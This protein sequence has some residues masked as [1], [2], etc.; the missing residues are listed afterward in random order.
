MLVH[1]NQVNGDTVII[2]E[3]LE[4]SSVGV[5]AS[6]TY[7]GDGNGSTENTITFSSVGGT[8]SEG[9]KALGAERDASFN[10]Y[11]RLDTA[12]NV[13]G[14]QVEEPSSTFFEGTAPVIKFGTTIDGVPVDD[15]LPPGTNIQTRVSVTNGVGDPAIKTMYSNIVTPTDGAALDGEMY[16]LR[17]DNERGTRLSR[18]S[19]GTVNV[20]TASYWVKPTTSPNTYNVIGSFSSSNKVFGIANNDHY[21]YDNVGVT[22]F[23]NIIANT[24]QHVVIRYDNGAT[25]T[26]LNGVQASSGSAQLAINASNFRIGDNANNSGAEEFDGYLS[27]FYFVQQALPPTTFGES[28][29]GKWA[30]RSS[31]DVV[32]T[33][34]DP[35]IYFDGGVESGG[36]MYADQPWSKA[37]DGV[38]SISSYAQCQQANAVYTF[39]SP[40]NFQTLKVSGGQN[41]VVRLN[42]NVDYNIVDGYEL[43]SVAGVTSPLT[44]VELVSANSALAAIEVDGKLLVDGSEVNQ[45]SVWSSEV[46]GDP[47]ITPGRPSAQMFDNDLATVSNIR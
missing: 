42:G 38:S 21:Y 24:W 34:N 5:V 31:A 37:F 10:N 3:Q 40:I 44:S 8:W 29:D 4:V 13:L 16:G 20:W 15:L 41:S 17:F 23:A 12:L 30:P 25:T 11:L 6:V 39:N 14:F 27:D 46:I 7:V 43:E 9:A 32:N 45:D 18:E 19:T 47:M 36:S 35:F 2:D 1:S 28:V 33:I 26:W 22:N